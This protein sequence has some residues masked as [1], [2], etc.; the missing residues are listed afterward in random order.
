VVALATCGRPLLTAVSER[1]R[2]IYPVYAQAGRDWLDGRRL[3]ADRD[4]YFIYRY[5]PLCAALLA[6]LGVLS[7]VAGA[8]CWRLLNLAVYLGGLAAWA[9]AAFPHD[10]GGTRRAQL[11]LL[12]APLSASGLIDGQANPLVIG[13]MLLAAVAAG[14][15]RWNWAALCVAL[16]C[17]VK[18]YPVAFGL[19]LVLAHPRRL[20]W[21][22]LLALALGL[23]APFLLRN[24]AYV[25]E[26][27]RG[28]VRLLSLDHGR[29]DWPLELSYRD[30]RL[31]CR[32]WLVPLSPALY[33]AVQLASAAGLAA[34]LLAGRAAG[35]SRRRLGALA[36]GLGSCWMLLLGPATEGCTYV[37]LAPTLALALV[38]ARGWR[39]LV[40]LRAALLAGFWLLV[41]ASAAVWFPGG[42]R[43]HEFGPH[44]LAAL[45]VLGC[46]LA[47]A[48]R[49]LAP[50]RPEAAQAL[51]LLV[52]G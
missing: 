21:R 1:H 4:G 39:N 29:Q 14:R 52:A 20:A 43:L 41:V 42:K 28:W 10:P 12:A 16:P 27:Y 2:G 7:P 25:A 38:P 18:L 8:C 45:L 19:L 47:G 51:P 15:D 6:P 37:L 36:L 33:L 24:P 50:R 48:A 13:L 22:C 3:Y 46:L 30:L 23:A 17:L 44:P 34:V 31:L 26:Q 35:W 40:A 32:V 5:S 9:R 49:A 11:L